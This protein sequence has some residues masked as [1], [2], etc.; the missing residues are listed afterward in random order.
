MPVQFQYATTLGL[1][2]VYHFEGCYILLIAS[3]IFCVRTFMT[4]LLWVENVDSIY[5]Q[6]VMNI[7]KSAEILESCFRFRSSSSF[8]ESARELGEGGVLD[9]D[10]VVVSAINQ[11]RNSLITLCYFTWTL[12]PCVRRMLPPCLSRRW[13]RRTAS[14]WGL[15]RRTGRRWSW[16]PT[17]CRALR[18]MRI[19]CR[20]NI[21]KDPFD[22]FSVYEYSKE[23]CWLGGVVI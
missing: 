5:K 10:V 4:S 14:S 12:R 22:N 17:L 16:C 9:G 18:I 1:I 15:G 23:R 3:S 11:W 13:R 2:F 7:I 21:L 8:V 6:I 20:I 19:M